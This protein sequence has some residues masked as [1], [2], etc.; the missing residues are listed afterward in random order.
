MLGRK[1]KLL[2]IILCIISISNNIFANNANHI[3]YLKSHYADNIGVISVGSGIILWE[4][5]MFDI[6]Y[7]YL[8]ERQET[9][10]IYTFALKR[11]V[12]V[13]KHQL[14]NRKTFYY[15]GF[16]TSYSITSNTYSRLPHYFPAGY[17]DFPNSVH[18]HAYLGASIQTKSLLP[19]TEPYLFAEVGS[20]DYAIISAIQN[21]YLKPHNIINSCFGIKIYLLNK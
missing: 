4:R 10:S 14:F 15:I 11:S 17:Y 13:L 9:H 18:F 7:G 2:A 6:N 16:M 5:V 3:F 20:Y 1:S 8:P 12:I 21:N 19:N